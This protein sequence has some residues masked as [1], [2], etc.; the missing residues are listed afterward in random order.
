M[1]WDTQDVAQKGYEHPAAKGID[2]VK[3]ENNSSRGGGSN[4]WWRDNDSFVFGSGRERNGGGRRA[5]LVARFMEH[6]KSNATRRSV[7]ASSGDRVE[8]LVDYLNKNITTGV[9]S[10]T[11][12]S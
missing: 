2:W 1:R 4:G 10:V 11:T 12:I 3:A 9:D 5:D 8:L 7:G 6:E